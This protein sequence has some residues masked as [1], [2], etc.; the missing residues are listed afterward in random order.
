[1][2]N[3]LRPI[4][5]ALFSLCT[6]K[7][8]L[9]LLR[10]EQSIRQQMQAE[11]DKLKALQKLLEEELIEVEGQ[12]VRVKNKIFGKSSERTPAEELPSEHHLAE[13]PPAKP[14]R[15]TR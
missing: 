5:E 6:R 11:I 3:I 15:K 1:M 7:D 12:Y 4:P 13:D 10:G 8:L 9:I 14:E 2:E